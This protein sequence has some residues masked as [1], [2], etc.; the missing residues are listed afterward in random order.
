MKINATRRQPNREPD[1]S[2]DNPALEAAGHRSVDRTRRAWAL[3]A[4]RTRRNR[5]SADSNAAEY[6]ALAHPGAHWPLVLD[7][8]LMT[9]APPTPD[10]KSDPCP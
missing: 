2:T 4:E 6:R 5:A 1:S 3:V 10:A 8:S 7:H 9:G